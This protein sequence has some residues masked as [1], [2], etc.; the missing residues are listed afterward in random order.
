MTNILLYCYG[1]NEDDTAS[2]KAFLG[3]KI[4][5]KF[6]ESYDVEFSTAEE[7]TPK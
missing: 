5:L 2:G 6:E 7:E 1:N 3:S 4:G